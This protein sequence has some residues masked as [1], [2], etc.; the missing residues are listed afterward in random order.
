MIKVYVANIE[1]LNEEELFSKWFACMHPMRQEKVLRCKQE[2]DKKRSLLTGILLKTA[3]ETEG[4]V[5]ENLD[6]SVEEHGKPVIK[7]LENI[8]FSLSHAGDYAL[9]CISNQPVGADVESMSKAV[10]QEEKAERIQLMAKKVLS[11]A[12]YECFQKCETSQKVQLF[13]KYWT[14]KESYSKVF[15]EGLRMN[16]A[17]ID[18]EHRNAFY[19][20]EWLDEE[21]FVSICTAEEKCLDVELHKVLELKI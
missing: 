17:D 20:S 13:L 1:L 18:T 7:N 15:G 21:H 12:E 6:F 10:F 5:Y 16:F 14:R 2:L 8:H 3:L 19:W 9:C 4:Y 11:K